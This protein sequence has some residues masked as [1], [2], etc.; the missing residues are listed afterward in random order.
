MLSSGAFFSPF[1]SIRDGQVVLREKITGDRLLYYREALN[2]TISVHVGDNEM[3]YFCV[4]GKTEA[5]Q[6]T[7]GM[8]V[9]RMIGHLPVLFHPNARTAM[10][11]GLGAGV[12]FGALGCHPLDHLEVVEIEP[13]VFAA[14]RLWGDLNHRITENPKA[15]FTYNDGRNHLFCTTNAYDVITSDPFEPVVSGAA[16][17]FTV[18]HF[19]NARN[20]LNDEGIMGQ[21]IPMYEMS[22]EDYLTIV[23][24]FVFVFPNTALFYT[25]FDTILIGFKGEM[26]LDA[27]VLRRNYA[28]PAVQASLSEIGFTE[29]EMIL[30]MFVA[31]L[32]RHPEFAGSGP[33][34]TDEHPIIEYNTP[35]SALR[36]TTDE[37]QSALL[38]IFTPIPEGWLEGLGEEVA[39]RLQKEHEAVRLMLEAAILRARGD[40]EN[41]FMTLAKALETSPANPVVKNEMVAM[42]TVSAQSLRASGEREEA[43][44]QFR[45]ALDLDP[46]NF[47]SLYYLVELGMQEGYAL[48]AGQILQEAVKH[49]PDSP[50][51]MGLQGKYLFSMGEKEKAMGLMREAVRLQP[52]SRRL[53]SDLKRLAEA[54]GDQVILAYAEQNLARLQAYIEGEAQSFRR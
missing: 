15:R 33:L 49:Y 35:K 3:R 51:V 24:S 27:D 22:L 19:A 23:R 1:N 53:W 41:A 48:F 50:L 11:L 25:G 21:W 36:Y 5:D 42:L 9:Q 46:K 54:T 26:K 47:W 44:R 52:G 37:N 40:N 13:S 20:R 17:L 30:G 2:S 32:S 4:D 45:A 38:T 12:S 34:N 18:D 8:V 6:G 29:P 39:S 43:A 14:A 10:N 28:V 7:R 16:K 31:D